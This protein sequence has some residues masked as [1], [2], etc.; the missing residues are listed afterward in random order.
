MVHRPVPGASGYRRPRLH[1]SSGSGHGECARGKPVRASSLSL[2]IFRALDRALLRTTG[3]P[4]VENAGDGT[5]FIGT[6]HRAAHYQ[7]FCSS[8]RTASQPAARRW[9]GSCPC[10]GG[11]ALRSDDETRPRSVLSISPGTR[12]AAPVASLA[13]TEL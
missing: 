9:F 1:H 11:L 10:E 2:R 6:F 12:T 13:G 4:S 5:A 7:I 3:G 8:E